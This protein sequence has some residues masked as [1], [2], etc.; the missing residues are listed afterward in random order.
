MKKLLSSI[1]CIA[2]VI[3][4]L[5]VS[6]SAAGAGSIQLRPT[7]G[8]AHP[9]DTITVKLNVT[10]NPG[11][12]FFSYT[13]SYDTGRLELVKMEGKDSSWTCTTRAN[14][15]GAGDETF[16][17][18]VVTLT[19]N[20][21][22]DA[23][24]GTA[25]IGGSVEAFNENE[26]EVSFSVSAGKVTISAAPHDHDWGNGEVTTKPGCE[27]KGVR[28]YTCSICGETRTEE[29]AATGHVWDNGV[30]TKEP[31]CSEPGVKTYT[32][33]ND[34][35]HTKTEEIPKLEHKSD[36]GTVTKEATCEKAGEKTYTCKR[37]SSHTKTEEIPPS[38]HEWDKGTVTKEATCVETGEKTYKCK[39][40][41]ETKTEIIAAKGH[42]WDKGTVTTKPTCTEPGV[43]T[44]TCKTCGEVLKKETI[45]ALGHNW[46]NGKVTKAPTTTQP[47]EKVYTCKND[48][49]HKKVEV[50]PATKT[51]KTGDDNHIE[52]WITLLAFS[53][54]GASATVIVGRKK[55]RTNK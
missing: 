2:L 14:W 43:K 44:Y 33:K 7:A 1:L 22:A 16:T 54:I 26:E 17:G 25:D 8:E 13:P 52:I 30:V 9:G 36:S 45:A 53:A 51:P 55:K 19:F 21:K 46:D 10:S 23:A 47:G 28:T 11:I 12:M 50:L 3:S 49:S 20:V 34:S 48:S 42:V 29:I 24:L 39:N 40:C 35:T 31:S 18:D 41:E 32:C 27:T 15:D 5:A 6:A 4:F 38:D 37:D